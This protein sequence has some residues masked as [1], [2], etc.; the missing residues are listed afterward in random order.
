[1]DCGVA[2]GVDI[3]SFVVQIVPKKFSKKSDRLVC[4]ATKCFHKNVLA[5]Y[6]KIC[7]F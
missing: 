4:R 1:M 6:F 5:K 7:N 2:R 3:L